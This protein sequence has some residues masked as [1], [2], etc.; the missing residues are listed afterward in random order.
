[1]SIPSTFPVDIAIEQEKVK[2]RRSRKERKREALVGWAMTILGK[3]RPGST[4]F[5]CGTQSFC[6]RGRRSTDFLEGDA[7]GR[8]AG[9][10][11]VAGQRSTRKAGLR[12]RRTGATLLARSAASSTCFPTGYCHL[13]YVRP[14]SA[15][16]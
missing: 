4:A 5:V 6:T 11:R 13:G 12:P 3:P 7:T 16:R 9:G 2:E 10:H 8:T 1:V 15:S 14:S